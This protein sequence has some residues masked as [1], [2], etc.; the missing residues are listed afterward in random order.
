MQFDNDI[1]KYITCYALLLSLLNYISLQR[2]KK[3]EMPI[4]A[5]PSNIKCFFHISSESFPHIQMWL[6]VCCQPNAML[7]Y[8]W[9]LA[10]P[11]VFEV[12]AW[13]NCIANST[14]W[15]INFHFSR[16]WLI[17]CIISQHCMPC[18]TFHSTSTKILCSNFSFS[19]SFCTKNYIE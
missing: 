7:I 16:F 14:S 2:T 12:P 19:N 18:S 5:M 15:K 17:K 4:Q 9:T 3:S 8:N 11:K 10:F 1:N 6:F 13:K